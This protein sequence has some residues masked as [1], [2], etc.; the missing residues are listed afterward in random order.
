MPKILFGCCLMVLMSCL[1]AQSFEFR[2]AATGL[3][4]TAAELADSLARHDVVFFGEWHGNTAIHGAQLE[5]TKLLHTRNPRLVL[6]FEMFERDV[7]PAL[8]AYL[9]EET[10]E[11]EF[12]AVSRP[13]SNY[14]SDYRPLVEFA[15][16]ESLKAVAANVP[17]RLAALAARLGGSWRD[18]LDEAELAFAAT[19]VHT[20]D[21]TYKQN[22]LATMGGMAHG[23]SEVA[24][25][26]E[27][28]YLAQCL[29]DDTMAESIL[30][31]INA[32]PGGK[33]LHFNGD[34][35]SRQFLGTVERLLWRLPGLRVAVIAPHLAGENLPDQPEQE[36]DFYLI[37]PKAE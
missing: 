3:A 22:F 31:A 19:Q 20:P 5:I 30:A 28:M 8:D 29:K 37:V 25:R 7:Q 18:V 17:R 21:G 32:D 15:R 23:N 26:V 14:P 34:F 1:S 36:A 11:D 6:S 10:S 33:I 16:S 35:H 9:R 12:L 27:N 24:A 2:S 13:W 4:I